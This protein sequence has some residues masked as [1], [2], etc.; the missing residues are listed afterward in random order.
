MDIDSLI[1]IG[2]IVIIIWKS[3][4]D[5]SK[6]TD[7]NFPQIPVP[8]TTDETATEEGKVEEKSVRNQQLQ[9]ILAATKMT[10][11]TKT[12]ESPKKQKYASPRKQGNPIGRQLR[13]ANGARRAFIYS[14]V[15]KNKY[16]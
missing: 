4:K 11:K 1:F 5:S 15:F 7:E 3:W 13:S 6:E 8:T 9:Q 10:G 2:A 12:A 14:E 16:N